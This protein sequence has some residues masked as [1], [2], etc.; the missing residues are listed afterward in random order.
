MKNLVV[1]FGNVHI[2]LH[3]LFI[4]QAKVQV[5]VIILSGWLH[6]CSQ[7]IF[8]AAQVNVIDNHTV[9]IARPRLRVDFQGHFLIHR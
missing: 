6:K 7:G 4:N 2:I 1:P 9:I 8:Y 3:L 5:W